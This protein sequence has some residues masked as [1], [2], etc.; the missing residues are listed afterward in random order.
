MRLG[1]PLFGDCSDPERWI[2]ALRRSGYR[3]AY[4]PNG[5]TAGSPEVGAFVR[6]AEA[7][8]VIAEVGAWSNPPRPDATEC[9]TALAHWQARPALADEA[10]RRG[11]RQAFRASPSAAVEPRSVA[12]RLE[13]G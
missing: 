12:R 10:W 4:Y 2:A 6:A 13:E 11:S 9:S 7:D 8:I 5:L 3:S 1:G